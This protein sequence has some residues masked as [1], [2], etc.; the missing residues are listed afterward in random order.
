MTFD[1]LIER[2]GAQRAV[3][4]LVRANRNLWRTW[5]EE[6]G[7]WNDRHEL[8][9]S[10]QDLLHPIYGDFLDSD[11]ETRGGT[12][13]L[14]SWLAGRLTSLFTSHAGGDGIHFTLDRT[15]LEPDAFVA[16]HV[17]LGTLT[18]SDRKY[19]VCTALRGPCQWTPQLL[20]VLARF[21]G[22]VWNPESD[23]PYAA[24]EEELLRTR[25]DG[26][27][28]NTHRIIARFYLDAIQYLHFMVPGLTRKSV[29]MRVR[30]IDHEFVVANLFGVPT[31]IA[32][33]DQLVGGS[34]LIL[35]LAMSASEPQ[36]VNTEQLR[37]T[38]CL[39][40]RIVLV[41]GQF[42]CGKSVLACHLAAAVARKGGFVNLASVEQSAAEY[43]YMF[44]SMGLL[45]AAGIA[46]QFGLGD[47]NPDDDE[48]REWNLG[49]LVY[50]RITREQ[51]LEA[52]LTM[53]TL[54]SGLVGAHPLRLL[55]I[56]SLPGMTI[57][58]RSGDCDRRGTLNQAF[59]AI[60]ALGVNLIVLE[61]EHDQGLQ[62]RTEEE[63][64]SDVVIRLSMRTEGGQLKR[65][66]QITKCRFQRELSGEHLFNIEPG[67]GF[68]VIPSLTA[69]RDA[70]A[71][72]APERAHESDP[73]PI[74]TISN[75]RVAP[76][77]IRNLEVI[78]GSEPKPG[79]VILI[80]GSSETIHSVIVD[81]FLSGAPS[82]ICARLD[83][84]MPLGTQGES[85]AGLILHHL[86][87]SHLV[88]PRTFQLL[89]ETF[90]KARTEG[91]EISRLVIDDLAAFDTD[92]T[93]ATT[94]SDLLTPSV[95]WLD[96]TSLR[97]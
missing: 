3:A 33:F 55:V 20:T 39:P 85:T 90:D 86:P 18:K 34:G 30:H 83:I 62:E 49:R 93:D 61:E 29:R 37:N 78:L 13:E 67:V 1:S 21:G 64:I 6:D 28:A 7:R 73:Q 84:G 97:S 89:D 47:K 51:L 25:V 41:R 56:D 52:T 4:G 76:Y 48:S 79:Q 23:I 35:Q 12:P 92:A 96:T 22:K 24:L 88:A 71:R 82:G 53:E 27:D 63:Y 95:L 2:F 66:L 8:L 68:N 36:P 65:V 44:H 26:V 74:S 5:V 72:R 9:C 75:D 46:V 80:E 11:D 91:L 14:R 45:P 15:F 10:I 77:G 60:A 87:H 17:P 19:F 16:R 43:L 38:P 31:G 40:G 81:A 70:L 69:V 54:A 58:A 42:G 32:G 94:D 57:S 59:K 50:T